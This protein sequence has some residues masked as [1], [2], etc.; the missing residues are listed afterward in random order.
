LYSKPHGVRGAV[1]QF[2]HNMPL[3]Q[4]DLGDVRTT[5]GLV[6]I[7]VRTGVE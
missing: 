5:T 1:C 2:E 4:R 3:T 7:L 6:A